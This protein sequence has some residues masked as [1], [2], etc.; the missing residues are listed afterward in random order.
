MEGQYLIAVALV[1]DMALGDPQGFPHPVRAI[2]WLA[3]KLET[4]LRSTRVPLVFAGGLTVFLVVTTSYL[5]CY[6]VLQWSRAIHPVLGEILLVLLIYTTLSLRGLYDASQPVMMAL[7]VK[8]LPLARKHLSQIVGRDTNL[9]DQNGIIRA[10][11]ETV[12]ENTIDG[13][14]AP[15]FFTFLGGAP[16]AVAYKAINTMDSLFGYKNERYE[17]FGKVA[18]R[19]DDAANWIPA[20]LGGVL[21]VLAAGICGFQFVTSLKAFFRDRLNHSSPNA[22]HPE[23]AAAGALGISLGGPLHYFGQM[24]SKPY[25]GENLR[26]PVIED[27]QRAQVLMLA[28]SLVSIFLFVIIF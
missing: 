7:L 15:L 28:T 16:L 12:S 22:G 21:M 26:E 8:D 5:V 11:V 18:A 6:W 13:V 3:L 19:L 27:I 2:A 25:I 10:T 1:L 17:Q 23:A 4:G 20:R 24:V 14:V 9:L